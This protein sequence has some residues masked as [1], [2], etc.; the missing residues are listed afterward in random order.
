MKERKN[1]G[2]KQRE[3]REERERERLA[4]GMERG[5]VTTLD[6]AASC[7]SVVDG[8]QQSVVGAPPQSLRW[9]FYIRLSQSAVVSLHQSFCT[10]RSSTSHLG[11]R[12]FRWCGVLAAPGGSPLLE[13][14]T[15]LVWLVVP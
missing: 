11:A 6:P 2:R 1:E 10:R 8:P 13:V 14:V 15:V 12:R 4:M 7:G 3:K 9:S 5:I